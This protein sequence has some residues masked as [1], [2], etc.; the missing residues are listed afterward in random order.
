HYQPFTPTTETLRGLL[1]GT[2][3]GTN[4]I[5]AVAWCIGI[6]LASYVWARHLYANRR[7]RRRTVLGAVSVEGLSKR[8]HRLPERFRVLDVRH[9]AGFGE[10]LPLRSRDPGVNL[11]DDVRRC[12]V[13]PSGH[14]KRWRRDLVQAVRDVPGLE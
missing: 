2:P 3:I 14:E 10:E 11:L 1:T 5:V 7:A 4:A 6:A 8:L 13:V 9:V 12:L